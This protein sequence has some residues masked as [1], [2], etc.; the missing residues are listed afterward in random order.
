MVDAGCVALTYD[1]GPDP[2]I[3]PR[4]LDVLGESDTKAT[5]FIVGECAVAH[6]EIV[7]RMAEDG[8]SVGTHSMHHRDLRRVSVALARAEV[9]EARRAVEDIVGRPVPLFRPPHG[10]LSARS[11]L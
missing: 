4:L 10:R 9:N 6:P 3:T 7:R 1:D 8:H 5:F 2:G 11:A